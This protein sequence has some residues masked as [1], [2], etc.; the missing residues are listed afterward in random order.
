MKCPACWAEKAYRRRTKRLTD[1][2]LGY[3]MVPM[4]CYH[5]YHEFHVPTILTLGKQITPPARPATAS[6]PNTLSYA[7]QRRAAE[8]AVALSAEYR[9][10]KEAV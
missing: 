8:Q 5:C 1:A 10:L 4:K 6:R 7:A 2:L 3:M 9:P